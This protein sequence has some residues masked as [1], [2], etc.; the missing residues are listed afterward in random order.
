[1]D[2][3]C[4]PFSSALRVIVGSNTLFLKNV[5]SKIIFPPKEMLLCTIMLMASKIK[6]RQ[7]CNSDPQKAETVSMS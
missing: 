4:I 6:T 3:K 7:I 5:T 2:N 1:M